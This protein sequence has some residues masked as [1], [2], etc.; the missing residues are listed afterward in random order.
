MCQVCSVGMGFSQLK[1]K[2]V[3]LGDTSEFDSSLVRRVSLKKLKDKKSA[4]S[5]LGETN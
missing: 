1:G 2:E 3:R 5:S 4:M